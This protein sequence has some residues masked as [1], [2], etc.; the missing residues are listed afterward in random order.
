[1]QITVVTGNKDKFD[2]ISLV[3][4][5][6]SI[7]PEMSH[8]DF[9]E[10]G[11]TL[12]EIAV[13][14]AQQA[15]SVLKKPLIVDD[16]GVFFEAVPDFP[17]IYAKRVFQEI[18]YAGLMNV[19]A[20]KPKNAFFRTVVCFTDSSAVRT[21]D[22]ICRGRIVEP[23]NASDRQLFPYEQIFVPEGHERRFS[24]FTLAEKIK[25]SHRA[26]AVAKFCEFYKE[27]CKKLVYD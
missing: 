7:E 18:G 25:I 1:M 27:H 26:I 13:S 11:K 15:F 6:Y 22:G 5:E 12:E 10:S 21:F 16:T 4:G 19:L 20:N 8:F 23:V 3:L 17:G 24:D 14:K 9:A 2:E